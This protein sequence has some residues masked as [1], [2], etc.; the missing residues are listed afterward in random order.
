MLLSFCS[1]RPRW[2]V[3][4]T[5]L[6]NQFGVH[7][8]PG[9][10]GRWE[11]YPKGY[12]IFIVEPQFCHSSIIWLPNF[13]KCT[14]LESPRSTYL[15][16]LHR[17]AFLM[18]L[19]L[20]KTWFLTFFE[21]PENADLAEYCLLSLQRSNLGIFLHPHAIS[22]PR[23]SSRSPELPNPDFAISRSNQPSKKKKWSQSIRYGST[24]TRYFQNPDDALFS[25]EY[26]TSPKSH[27]PWEII[28][29]P[30]S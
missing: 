20:R 4:T 23:L 2:A 8:L 28:P 24:K 22:V 16:K 18:H 19:K 12:I 26:V 30:T 5:P 27:R 9:P 17:F 21:A 13:T 3:C 7:I 6:H 10:E 15:E 14:S 1:R 11:F 29:S 25:L